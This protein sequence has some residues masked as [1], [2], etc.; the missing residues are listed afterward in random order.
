M[1]EVSILDVQRA[2]VAAAVDIEMSKYT[3]RSMAPTSE[4]IDSLL[5]IKSALDMMTSEVD[6]QVVHSE[7]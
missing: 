6:S 4:V 5:D 2:M 7:V 1:S 3:G